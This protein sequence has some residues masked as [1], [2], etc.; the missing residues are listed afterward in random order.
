MKQEIEIKVPNDYSA[1]TFRKYLDLQ[2]DLNAY[3]DDDEAITAAVFYHLCGIDP[4]MLKKIDNETYYKIR[5]QLF[6]FL[7][8]HDYK[9]KRTLM[10]NGVEYG[11]EPNLSEMSYGA[12][13]D[14]T[15]YDTLELNDN[16]AKIMSILYRPVTQKKGALYSIE[17]YEGKID[18]DLFYD[19]TMDVHFGTYFFFINLSTDLLNVILNSLT[20][21]TEIP[22][23]IKSIL[24]ESGK[25][26]H[27]S[28]HLP[29]EIY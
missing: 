19:V 11:F 14:I 23:N 21:Q 3:K 2:K 7:S 22:T 15:K 24:E 26:I 17:P 12:Y 28:L 8:S 18:N 9:L 25:L 13:V 5:E 1:I 4:K 27:Q 20:Q 29:K 10:I 6:S 16:W